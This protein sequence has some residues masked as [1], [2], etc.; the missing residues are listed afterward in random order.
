RVVPSVKLLPVILLVAIID[1]DH[2]KKNGKTVDQ[3]GKINYF[4]DSGMITAEAMNFM[5]GRSITDT[6][7]IIDEAQNL[8][9]RQVKG[10]VTRVGKGTKVILL[11]DPE[12][13]DHPLLNEQ[14]NGLSYAAD[15][16]KGSSL[17]VQQTML[18]TECERSDLAS[19]AATRM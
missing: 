6:W 5:R 7:M 3:Q 14:N 13:I 2:S 19:D 9:P 15:R 10:V 4:L 16:M 17:C 11:G 12:Q 8:T 18:P 1:L